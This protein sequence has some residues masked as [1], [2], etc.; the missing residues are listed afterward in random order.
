MTRLETMTGKQRYRD[1]LL[2]RRLFGQARPFGW[3]IAAILILSLLSAPLALLAPLPLKIVVD[4]V[5][6]PHPLPGFLSS[7]LPATMERSDVV[8]IATALGLVIFLGVAT[9]LQSFASLVLSTYTGEKLI[10]SFRARLFRHVQDFSLLYHDSKG[11]A[12][13]IYRIQYDAPAIRWVTVDG[14][15]PIITAVVTLGS[16]I[17]VTALIELQLALVAVA[18]VPLLY[19]A[20]RVS[21][22]RL[23]NQ[24]SEIK[25]VESGALSV[26]QE[27]LG[28]VRVV[29]AFG[30]EDREHDRFVR[31][32]DL[33]MW[34][35]VR[36]AS[37]QGRLNLMLGLITAAGTAAVLFVGVRHVQAGTL[38][39]G[40]LLLVM[41]YL[42][43]LYVPLETISK[44]IADVQYSL[45]S[46]ERTFALLDERVEVEE[47]LDGVP[48]VRAKGAVEFRNVDF[49]YVGDRSVLKDVSF[50]AEPGMRIGIAGTTGSGKTTL[51][52][53]I[54]RLYDPTAGQ[55]LL[56]G[57]DLRDFRL[58]DLRNQYTVV[59][60]EPVLFST[61]IG[62]NIA[63]ARP[64]ASMEEIIAA[65]SAAN[66][67]EF[68][69]RLPDG[70]D[71]MVGERGMSLSGGERQR[72]SLARAFLKDAPILI[73]DE[74]TSSVDNRTEASIM[75]AVER[76]ME[77]RTTFI[78]AHRMSTL[79]GCDKLLVVDG[80]TLVPS[81][82]HQGVP[83]RDVEEVV[84]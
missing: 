9:Q 79:D 12:D 32:A 41:G 24:W 76:L 78:I 27:V 57:V 18:I 40:E 3:H 64:D 67:H 74:P 8:A 17:Y 69:C 29:K 75:S 15:I 19:L 52:S 25:E 59:L 7:L 13:S 82:V 46:A 81:S 44:K 45:A 42:T 47:R 16:M 22:R 23:R 43:Q 4:S 54:M 83:F 26:V 1:L 72:I 56:D 63:Y 68:I 31:Q 60:Q 36:L 30:Q 21:G 70:Y 5:L 84:A 28:A 6:G 39:L 65:A 38:T 48:L 77:S 37:L 50:Q 20:T 33:G 71:S 58:A 53:L 80:G 34:G 2:F 10:L 55:V 51:V 49:A 66:A 62:E 11:T 73:L 35:N 14:T 61:S